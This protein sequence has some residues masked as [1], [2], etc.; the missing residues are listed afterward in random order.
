[1]SDSQDHPIAPTN[2]PALEA[3]FRA[4]SRARGE[5]TELVDDVRARMD[6]GEYMSAEK[7]N[8]AIHRMLKDSLA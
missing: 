5:R 6:G 2:T 1:M 7:L 4:L 8:L 3:I